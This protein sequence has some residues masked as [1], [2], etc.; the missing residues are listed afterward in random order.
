MRKLNLDEKRR[1]EK[2]L[3]EDI[4][5]KKEEYRK[6]RDEKRSEFIEK[7]NK[8]I[9]VAIN[10]AFTEYKKYKKS[11]DEK[12]SFINKQGY[13]VNERNDEL[14][15]EANTWVG[16]KPKELEEYDKKTEKIKENLE[17]VKKEYTLKLY[18]DTDEAQLLFDELMK[19]LDAV[20]KTI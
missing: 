8:S 6:K 19:K 1:I 7:L 9:P 5:K 16:T 10:K 12:E 3:L 15:V 13:E 4:E 11:A 14:E 17:A 2:L 18:A 20:V